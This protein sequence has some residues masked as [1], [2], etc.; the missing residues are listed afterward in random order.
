MLL[1]GADV[2]VEALKAEFEE[3]QLL[4]DEIEDDSSKTLDG[5][6]SNP[7]VGDFSGKKKTSYVYTS[8]R[9]SALSS[10]QQCRLKECLT[11]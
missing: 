2:D 8:H 6:C 1:L 11:W 10:T 7:S 9:G 5:V 4:E 3:Y